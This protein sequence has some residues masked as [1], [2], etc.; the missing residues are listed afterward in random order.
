MAVFLSFF[1]SSSFPLL[2]NIL[3]PHP[4][5]RAHS[6]SSPQSSPSSAS[7][8]SS[9]CSCVLLLAVIPIFVLSLVS[10]CC[11]SRSS[12]A[13]LFVHPSFLFFPHYFISSTPFP[14][15]SSPYSSC[16]YIIYFF[17]SLSFF[18]TFSHSFPFIFSFLMVLCPSMFF[19]SMLYSPFLRLLS[20]FTI[21]LS[22]LLSF[23]FSFFHIFLF[24]FLSPSSVSFFLTISRSSSFCFSSLSPYQSSVLQLV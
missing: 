8:S 6:L 22:F 3:P 23:Y 19:L 18:L 7:H 24:S 2:F 21:F 20:V 5:S 15:F 12:S 14:L 16:S 17:L 10:L 13:S 4:L 11:V 1:L 9:S